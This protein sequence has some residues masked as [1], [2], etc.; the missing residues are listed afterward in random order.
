MCACACAWSVMSVSKCVR[1]LFLQ[2]ILLFFLVSQF[3]VICSTCIDV[4]LYSL[5]FASIICFPHP[6][7]PFYLAIVVLYQ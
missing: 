6:F 4:C 7:S 5:V 1:Q 2:S 3:V